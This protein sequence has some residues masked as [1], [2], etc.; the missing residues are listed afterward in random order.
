MNCQDIPLY[1]KLVCRS[2]DLRSCNCIKVYIFFDDSEIL[3]EKLIQG[4]VFQQYINSELFIFYELFKK[5]N[6]YFNDELHNLDIDIS[7]SKPATEITDRKSVLL[8]YY[9]LSIHC[10]KQ[11]NMEWICNSAFITSRPEQSLRFRPLECTAN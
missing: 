9:L 7:V 2:K 4:N 8:L 6:N 11:N 10:L 3:N 5:E 1:S